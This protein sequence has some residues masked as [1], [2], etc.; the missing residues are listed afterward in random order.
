MTCPKKA[1][2]I[3][4]QRMRRDIPHNALQ[5]SR[6]QIL[7]ERLASHSLHPIQYGIWKL[8][9]FFLATN[10]IANSNFVDDYKSLKVMAE[11]N[12]CP[13]EYDFFLQS[14]QASA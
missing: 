7:G 6:T 2:P 10:V 8:K 3:W 11:D 14:D 5:M 12:I 1:Q 4:R 9:M 13:S